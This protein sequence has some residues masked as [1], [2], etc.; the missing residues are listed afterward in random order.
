MIAW[1]DSEPSSSSWSPSATPVRHLAAVRWCWPRS[2]GHRCR[3]GRH[4]TPHSLS[5]RPLSPCLSLA[6]PPGESVIAIAAER[7][8]SSLR[9]RLCISPRLRASPSSPRAPPS[10]PA[11]GWTRSPRGEPHF[12]SSSS[13]G[14]RPSRPRFRRTSPLLRSPLLS[15]L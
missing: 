5:A 8:A 4:D 7:F 2:L 11:L 1:S 12:T 15:S 14:S 13:S 10:S 9:P 3:H 6:T